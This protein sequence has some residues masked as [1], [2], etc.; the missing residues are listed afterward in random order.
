MVVN[1]FAHRMHGA[2]TFAC[3]RLLYWADR[4]PS[5]SAPSNGWFGSHLIHGS[6]DSQK[7]ALKRHVY[8]FSSFSTAHPCAQQTDKQTDH[9]TC[10]TRSKRLHPIQMHCMQ[11]MWPNNTKIRY[12]LWVKKT[13]HLTFDHNYVKCRPINKFFHYHIPDKFC[14]YIS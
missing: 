6:L 9:T 2:G 5:K 11:A 14:T 7:S 10:D 4:C 3:G 13:I 8:Q 12:T 1:A